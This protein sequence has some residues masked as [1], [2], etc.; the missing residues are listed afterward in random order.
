MIDR[1]SISIKYSSMNPV[2]F[3]QK[4]STSSTI[5]YINVN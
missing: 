2:L 5:L 1:H 4:V 3:V